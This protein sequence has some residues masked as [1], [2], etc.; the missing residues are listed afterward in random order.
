[1]K[2]E[3]SL[4]PYTKINSKWTKDLNIRLDILKLLQENIGRTI[5]DINH[6]NIFF[7]PPPRVMKIKTKINRWKLLK[8]KSFS[9]AK[10]TMNKIKRQLTEQ[11]KIFAKK[12]TDKGLISKINKHLMKLYVNKKK[13]Q[14]LV[15]I[16]KQTFLQRRQTDAQK[17]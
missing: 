16:S 4:T 10:E 14:K 8:L 2:L 17:A 3:P 7:D 13:I 9:I 15:K 6:N 12:A 1:M 11:E 5:F